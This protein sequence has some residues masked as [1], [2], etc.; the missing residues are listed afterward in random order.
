[1]KIITT[2]VEGKWYVFVKDKDGKT[3]LIDRDRY[4]EL[5]AQ[6]I[7]LPPGRPEDVPGISISDGKYL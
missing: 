2:Q 7:I 6:G 5:A 4:Y 3:V 1:M